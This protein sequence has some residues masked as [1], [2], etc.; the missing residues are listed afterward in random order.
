VPTYSQI[1]KRRVQGV[2]LGLVGNLTKDLSLSVGYSHMDSKILVAAVA[3]QGGVLTFSPVN[4][5]TSWLTYKLP[6]GITVGGG[7]RYVDTAARS[8]NVA[9]PTSNLLQAPAYWVGDAMASYDI[10]KNWQVQLNVYNLFDKKYM[11]SLNNGGSRY[12]PGAP[13][14]G[15]ISVNAKF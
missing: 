10:S 7:M 5:F 11:Q 1:G 4:T 12:T 8:S 14:N 15:L 3:S 6:L 9:A 13:R 2:E